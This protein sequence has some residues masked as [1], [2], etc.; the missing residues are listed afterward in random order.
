MNTIVFLT[1]LL[2]APLTAFASSVSGVEYDY[3]G[4]FGT[5]AVSASDSG[6]FFTLTFGPELCVACESGTKS[7]KGVET[8]KFDA[9]EGVAITK[10][11]VTS[12]GKW[13]IETPYGWTFANQKVS[14]SADDGKVKTKRDSE[15]HGGVG[16]G[17]FRTANVFN[18]G[19]PKDKIDLRI[20]FR[21]GVGT[22]GKDP[23]ECLKS[24]TVQVWTVGSPPP[25]D[26]I[27]PQPV[28]LPP[29]VTLLASAFAGMAVFMRRPPKPRS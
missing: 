5:A 15:S 27:P 21:E 2:L 28:P 26:P 29:S 8:L 22:M 20:L 7:V 25:I 13:G 23:W 18:F 11:K 3:G 19:N 14:L 12:V 6:E 1:A 16:E 24:V 9:V 17:K 10:I 4:A